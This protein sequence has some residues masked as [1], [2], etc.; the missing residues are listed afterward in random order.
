MSIYLNRNLY[1]QQ[2]QQPIRSMKILTRACTQAHTQTMV[3]LD[4]YHDNTIKF[5]NA[6]FSVTSLYHRIT[7]VNLLLLLL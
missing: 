3:L 7:T 6:N 1:Q 2:K 4:M 5:S